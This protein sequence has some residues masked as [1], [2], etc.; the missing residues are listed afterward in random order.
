[1]ATVDQLPTTGELDTNSY[2]PPKHGPTFRAG[3]ELLIS[4]LTTADASK[5]SPDASKG[6]VSAMKAAKRDLEITRKTFEDDEMIAYREFG[7]FGALR[8]EQL[9]SNTRVFVSSLPRSSRPSCL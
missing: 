7:S 1:M 8:H 9:G 5:G 2:E 3:H 4:L 6:D